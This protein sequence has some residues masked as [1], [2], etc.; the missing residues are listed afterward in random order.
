MFA[1]I[2]NKKKMV[3]FLNHLKTRGYI[4]DKQKEFKK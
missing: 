2:T 1:K 4:I 3:K